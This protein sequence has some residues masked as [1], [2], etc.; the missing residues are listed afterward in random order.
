M[1]RLLRVLGLLILLIFGAVII[2]P[3]V[4][5]DELIELA[6]EEINK[7]VDADVAIGEFDLSL[8]R[9]FPDF[10]LR[11]EDITVDGKGKFNGVRLLDLGE[12][13]LDLD[14][15]SVVSGDNYTIKSIA[16]ND[17]KVHVIVDE[18]GNANYD[19]A[20][21]TEGEEVEN[22]EEEQG[23]TEDSKFQLTL[24]SW[25]IENF[26][27]QFDDR[28]AQVEAVIKDFD[29]SGS[30][31]F[32]ND[33]VDVKTKTLI[34]ALTVKSEG[35]AYLNKVNTAADFDIEINQ[36]TGVFTFGDNEVRMNDLLLN[37]TGLIGMPEGENMNMDLS[38]S[39][40]QST[41]KSVL[42]LIP[43]V[44]YEGFEELK[45]NGIFELN[46]FVKGEFDEVY[47]K[48]PSYDVKFN[49]KEG[50]IQYPDLPSSVEG[51]NI[52]TH[53]YNTTSD[54][55]GTIIDVP[56]AQAV[57]AGSPI[58][59]SMN[60][61]TPMSDP[62][63]KAKASTD[64]ELANL[65][66]AIPMDGLVYTGNVKGDLTLAAKMSDIDNEL[67]ENVKA[68]GSVLL[69]QI[70]LAGEEVPIPVGISEADLSF[71]PEYLSLKTFKMTLGNS[72][73][74]AAGRI[75][76]LLQYALRDD[77][78]HGSFKV[79]SEFLDLN[80]LFA[81]M[82]T[83]STVAI[84][85]G[86]D[87]S[88]E[89]PNTSPDTTAVAA[90]EGAVRIPQNLDFAL[91]THL[92]RV[93]FDSLEIKNV[94]G[95]MSLKKGA[96]SMD[97][98]SMD[99]IGGSMIMAGTYDSKPVKPEVDMD[100]K[101]DN[102]GFKES[103]ESLEMVR[104]MVPI[105]GKTDGKY[106]TDFHFSSALENDMS[107]D[108]ASILAKGNLFTDGLKTSPKSMLKLSELLKNP[109][110]A[111]LDIGK[112]N[113]SFTIADGRVMVEPFEITAGNVSSTVS[114]SNGLD[115]TL[116]YKMDMK[117]PVSG[118]KTSSVLNGLGASSGGKVD[119]GVNIGGTFLDPKISTSVGDIL[120]GVV[121]NIK[122]QI[123]QKVDEVKKQ[124]V[125]KVNEEA[126]K[127]IAEAEAQGDIL[128]AEAQKS[129]E[130]IKA[131][132]AVQAKKLRDEAEKQALKLEEEAKGN[133][134]KEAAAKQA[135]KGIRENADKQANKVESE[136]AL[137]FQKV[138][139]AAKE[140]K[141]ILVEAAKAK[142]K[143]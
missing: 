26:N 121:E 75:D 40:P 79:N 36:T 119:L 12:V 86:T 67:Y 25:S 63:I 60:L 18:E 120:G 123:T 55:D 5:E 107:P 6:T 103:F 90:S 27:L 135:A 142:A 118:I 140:K 114:G 35:I 71:A 48:Y 62:N 116:D 89:T 13:N 22:V 93:L 74:N 91:N 115:Q 111:T 102:F 129:A 65:A 106:S 1:K 20:I 109:S 112:V 8:L 98:L 128:I 127:L 9:S 7:S 141:K 113:L 47:E 4:F 77:S 64:F 81:L 33:L 134:L 53:V 143:L 96:V 76:N 58:N 125:D 110:L 84:E 68:E 14:L 137:Q 108:L 16:V 133:F 17:T 104:Q 131:A 61:S 11:M 105:M 124:A 73:L 57:I 66:K 80:E 29:H 54:L 97:N 38:F 59:A 44:Y 39:T 50:S 15:L 122:Q 136:A 28:Q 21:E 126:Q 99:L 132:A 101:I 45:T 3:I 32:S 42:S 52:N 87:V 138:V 56:M 82:E 130:A 24:E 34:E 51:I 78:L 19:I 95:E 41:F 30:G 117:I 88:A 2:L 83:D 49:V 139:D 23:T 100:F 43:S 10:N 31:N 85:S 94:E 92:K 70:R 69:S 46:G 37:F 72:D